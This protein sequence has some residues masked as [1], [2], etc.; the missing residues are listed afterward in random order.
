MFA[1][2]YIAMGTETGLL[3]MLPVFVVPGNDTH[4]KVCEDFGRTKRDPR[5]TSYV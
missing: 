1:C 5:I 4:G 3:L 2:A